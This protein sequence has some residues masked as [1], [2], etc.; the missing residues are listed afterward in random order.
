M[1]R[2]TDRFSTGLLFILLIVF[3]LQFNEE[4]TDVTL[5]LPELFSQPGRTVKAFLSPKALHEGHGDRLTVD[6]SIKV[7]DV[8]L[9][10]ALVTVKRMPIFIIP[11]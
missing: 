1:V 2:P 7:E 3:L 9:Q 5:I 11:S 6:V 4:G 10:R 8:N